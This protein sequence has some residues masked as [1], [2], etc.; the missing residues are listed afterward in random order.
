[1]TIGE[2]QGTSGGQLEGRRTLIV[3]STR[4]STSFAKYS[5]IN[6]YLVFEEKQNL[7]SIGT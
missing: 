7:F 6:L 2:V 3:E 4:F 5:I 1:M